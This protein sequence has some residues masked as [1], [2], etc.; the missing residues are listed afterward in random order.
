MRLG[1]LGRSWQVCLRCRVNR[2]LWEAGAPQSGA[3]SLVAS[4]RRVS[5]QESPEI[6]GALMQLILRVRLTESSELHLSSSNL[7]CFLLVCFAVL[8]MEHRAVCMLSKCSVTEPH[9]HP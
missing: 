1:V 9:P 7:F 3:E 6:M 5:L 2:T 8:E 4:G